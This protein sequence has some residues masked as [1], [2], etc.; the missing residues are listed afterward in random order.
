LKK[1]FL[2]TDSKKDPQRVV[3]SI[4]HDIRK[5][6]KREKRKE[7]PKGTDFWK[8]NSKFGQNADDAVEIK[9]EDIMK[10]IDEASAQKLE[11]FY[12]ELISEAGTIEFKKREK[13][14]DEDSINDNENKENKDKSGNKDTDRSI[15]ITKIANI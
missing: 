7:L 1:T 8:I 4:K 12:I 9:F 14:E 6:I 13:A 15:D 2:L 10:N 5:Y 11:S 3:E